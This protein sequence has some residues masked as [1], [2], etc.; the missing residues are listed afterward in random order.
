MRDSVSEY[1]FTQSGRVVLDG[2]GNGRVTL[3]PQVGQRWTVA[4]A[5]VLV[6]PALTNIPQCSL[7][8][9]GDATPDAFIDGT[10]TGNLNS[11]DALSA[12]P[13]SSGV[14]VIAVWLGG[15]AGDTATLTLRG[16]QSTGNS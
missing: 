2:S 10:Y 16:T 13:V 11:T 3:T 5:S 14:K 4:I 1:P 8:V 6:Q 15:D 7:Y 9:G 12:H